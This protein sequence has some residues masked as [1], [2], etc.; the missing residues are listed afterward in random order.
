VWVRK[1]TH[2]VPVEALP[3]PVSNSQPLVGSRLFLPLED[4]EGLDAQQLDLLDSVPQRAGL[5]ALNLPLEDLPC[6]LEAT[7]R[8]RGLGHSV[9]YLF[10]C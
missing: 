10:I 1:D 5:A 8:A 9:S 6:L 7:Q 3:V 2:P 4:V